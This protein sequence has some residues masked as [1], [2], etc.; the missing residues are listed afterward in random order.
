MKQ[1]RQ[2]L[3]QILV[4]GLGRTGYKIFCLLRDQGARVTGIHSNPIPGETEIIVGD[5]RAETTLL[6]AGI[7]EAHTL[8][9]TSG[10]DTLNLSILVQ[11][12]LLNP[13]IRVINRLFNHSLG[14]RLDL[15][16]TDHVTLSVSELAA[17]VFTFAALGNRA[18]GQLQLFEQTWPIY[19]ELISEDHPWQGR[20]LRDLWE[21]RS[22]MMI[23]YLPSQDPVD[24]VTAIEE[25]RVLEV[26][27]RLIIATRPNICRGRRSLRTSFDKTWQSLQR[28]Q[29]YGRSAV[30]VTLVL[31]ITIF[32][33]TFTYVSSNFH[34]SMVSDRPVA[35]V[36]ALYFSVGMITGAGGN[37]FVVENASAF[38]KIFTVMMMLVGA[39]VVGVFY[40]LLNDLVLGTHF[41]RLWDVAHVPPR[42]HFVICG[43]GG[44]G[45]KTAQQLQSQGHEV[46]VIERD[47]QNRFLSTVRSL[48][49]PV[50]HGDASLATT[51]RSANIDKAAALL[52]VTSN[53]TANLEIALSAKGLAPRLPVVV[54][55]QD[56]QFADM[57]QQVFAFDAVLSPT[58]LAAPSFAAAA[59]G[60]R[61]LGNGMAA[62]T[63]WIAIATLITPNH[64][65]CNQ[66]I[67][68]AAMAIDFVPLYLET[69][70]AARSPASK[71]TTHGWDLLNTQ[72]HP[73][74]I[75]YL[76]LPA[77]RLEQ[78][79]RWS[80][81]GLG[82]SSSSTTV[83]TH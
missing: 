77:H 74:D 19:E 47:V 44:V 65:F 66:H 50:I 8:V 36:D 48:K 30:L 62:N 52:A 18:I 12:R 81:T 49:I 64:P 26:G 75:L 24:L 38:T 69:H 5:L 39:A 78:L 63:L 13:Q 82:P 73:G 76:T 14:E 55:N 43:L 51:L 80:P 22:R 9:L 6:S 21:D 40:A 56:P 4:C 17:P 29:Q 59:L 2:P 61:I 7:R 32:I 41:R 1:S 71:R 11:A 35:I 42:N 10:D 15:T 57:A 53:D 27:D 46:V 23:Y 20:P 45:V 34:T 79:W 83:A 58:E 54:R 28:F 70:D 68:A 60:G 67:K 33:A 37:E 31:L 16:L 3:S 25:R 72:L